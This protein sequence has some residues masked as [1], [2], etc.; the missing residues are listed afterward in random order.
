MPPTINIYPIFEKSDL[1]EMIKLTRN[2]SRSV[3]Q[4]AI[5]PDTHADTPFSKPWIL[6]GIDR[7]RRAD[8]ALC[9]IGEKNMALKRRHVGAHHSAKNEQKDPSR[10]ALSRDDAYS[11]IFPHRSEN[12]GFLDE[13]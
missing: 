3:K 9:M 8:I 6:R 10:S 7:I 4:L 11:T 1:Y 5:L 12:E 2:L 13:S